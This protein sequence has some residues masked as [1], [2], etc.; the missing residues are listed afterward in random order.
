MT[1]QSSAAKPAAFA[2]FGAYFT[3]KLKFLRS[4][5]IFNSILALLTYPLAFGLMIPLSRAY[6]AMNEARNI[7][8]A[9]LS[10]FT[11]DEVS[12]WAGIAM[13]GIIICAICLEMLFVFTLATTVRGFRYLY[14]KNFVDMDYSLPINNNTRFCADTLAALFSSIVPHLAAIIIGMALMNFVD[15]NSL[16]PN[17][18]KLIPLIPQYMFVGLCSCIMLVGLT[19]LML[20]FC[21]KKAEA[22]IYPALINIAIPLIHEMCI[23]IVENNTYGAYFDFNL[24]SSLQIGVTSP[25]GM[26]LASFVPYF[27]LNM[28]DILPLFWPQYGLPALAV[29][30]IYFAAAYFI[31]KKR[32]NERVG[33]PYVFGVMNYII[34]G[35]VIL[36]LVMPLATQ[37][38]SCIK[39]GVESIG[40]L[41]GILVSTF[42]LY[43]IM[44][45]ISG[46]G[47]RKFHL[48][49]AKWAGTAAAGMAITALLFWSNGLGAA[50]YVPSVNRVTSVSASVF[51]SGTYYYDFDDVTDAESIRAVTEA[52]AAI[53]K[54][55][56]ADG[57]NAVYITYKMKDGSMFSRVYSLTDEYSEQFMRKTVTPEL[58]YHNV[59]SVLERF[60]EDGV[61]E[62]S[63]ISIPSDSADADIE[64]KTAGLTTEIMM[65]A[66][67]QDCADVD[68]DKAFN[69]R[70][71]YTFGIN[72][73]GNCS[74][75]SGSGY[76]ETTRSDYIEL[77]SWMDNTIEL[78]RQY[79]VPV[80]TQF[81]ISEYK[82]AYIIKYNDDSGSNY[83]D[84]A[85]VVGLSEG[86]TESY[87]K[88]SDTIE[89]FSYSDRYSFAKVDMSDSRFAEIIDNMTPAFSSAENGVRYE[90]ILGTWENS[91][92]YFSDT[93]NPLYR[94]F[95]PT[96]YYGLAEELY[97][98]YATPE[99]L[100][101]SGVEI[102]PI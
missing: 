73:E 89:Y 33:S 20:S 35:V 83:F 67:R 41:I 68:Y 57:N 75:E 16:L 26:I 10:A 88:G 42:V 11:H 48:T 43:T 40:W 23:Y 22:F 93:Y 76:V 7:P 27:S 5:F 21:G 64:V 52:H 70:G 15:F 14:D 78:L 97:M 12:R 32:R 51:R 60:A 79:G 58:F 95:F 34:P 39:N 49:A 82:S 100:A 62:I 18:S 65:N 1:A 85:S 25:L 56:S 31:M 81:D 47:F 38:F 71:A 53:P 6:T 80:K 66:I 96:E 13:A 8:G 98:A 63:E 4:N 29:T 92:E 87:W 44:A 3:Y 17:E 45:L 91:N 9:D 2:K 90:L 102:T 30:L 77:Y 84:V 28:P 99:T 37:M 101:M 69:T 36:A 46:K 74:E 54:D 55:G 59:V 50:Y 94:V 61:N 24:A 72:A 86:L 19:M